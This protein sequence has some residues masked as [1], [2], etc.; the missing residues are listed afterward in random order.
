MAKKI[1]GIYQITCT[2]NGKRYVGQN[3]DIKRR[4]NQHK[5]KPP[6][7]VREDFELYGVD[8]FTFEVLEECAPEELTAR[9]DFYLST[10]KPEYNIRT[11]GHGISDKAREKLRLNHTGK[12]RPDISRRV[13]C[14]ETGGNVTLHPA[15]VLSNVLITVTVRVPQ[16][17]DDKSC[18]Y[19]WKFC[20]A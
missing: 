11:E 4:F 3:I 18:G 20:A 2:V 15:G 9:E 14:V 13:K 8:K 10:L 6:D 12:K 5:R 19:H 1:I 17:V 7:G 16:R